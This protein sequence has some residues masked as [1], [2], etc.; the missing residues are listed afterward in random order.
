MN[1]GEGG[2]QVNPLIGCNT[3]IKPF[4]NQT[5]SLSIIRP[6]IRVTRKTQINQ[7]KGIQERAKTIAKSAI[8]RT[9]S[10]FI[11]LSS[12]GIKIPNT[13]PGNIIIFTKSS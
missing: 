6:S 9:A 8:K 2:E 1:D 5:K 7:S 12:D 3:P 11:T 10:Q 4:F 13:K